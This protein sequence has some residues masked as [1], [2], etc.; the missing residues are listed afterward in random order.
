MKAWLIPTLGTFL[1]WGLWGFLPKLAVKSINPAS[2]VLYEALGGLLIGAV[3][4]V[5]LNFKVDFHPQGALM[6]FVTG[7]LGILGAYFFLIAVTRGKVSLVVTSTALYPI[8]TI[9]LAVI[10]LHETLTPKQGAGI[11]L[12]LTAIVLIS[13]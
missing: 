3:A 11:L 10:F 2:A 7:A 13:T 4:L 6:A 8:F 12:A 5:F 9:L 1:V